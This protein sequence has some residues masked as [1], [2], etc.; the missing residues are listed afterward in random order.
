MEILLIVIAIIFCVILF[1][2]TITGKLPKLFG[3]D[4]AL[5]DLEGEEILIE[6]FFHYFKT[7]IVRRSGG[8]LGTPYLIIDIA[9][10]QG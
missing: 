9:D 10:V 2:I 4:P 1:D 3:I 8:D 7:D 5:S 6:T